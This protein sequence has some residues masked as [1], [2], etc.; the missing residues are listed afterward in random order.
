MRSSA[1]F[2][3]DDLADLDGLLDQATAVVAMWDIHAGAR[4]PRIVGL[5]HDV[6][7]RIEPAVDMA[8][9]EA[10]RGYRATYYILHTAPYWDNKALLE[11]SLHTISEQGHEIGIHNNALAESART[12]RD[13]RLIL[14]EAIVELQGYGYDIQGTVAHG[15]PGCYGPD[16][17]VA[18]VNDQLFEECV[19]PEYVQPLEPVPLHQFGLAYD[20]NWLGR[21]AYLSDSGGRWNPPG[22]QAAADLFPFLQGQ[23]HILVHPDWWAEAFA[24][25]TLQ[26]ATHG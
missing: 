8:A 2:Q 20:A 17:Q 25:I 22:F 26:E 24:P 18:F 3:P 7:N 9:W 13:P 1:P 19:R 4:D 12:G 14:V 16:G 23:L 15:D 21:G 6:D 5:R 10:E 11:R